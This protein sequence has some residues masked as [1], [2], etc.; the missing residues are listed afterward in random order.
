[1]IQY[2]GLHTQ[3]KPGSD[4]IHDLHLDGDGNLAICRN[5][6]AVGQHARQRVMTYEGE[7]FLDTSAGVPWLQQILG[8]K[9]D[10][11][12]TLAEAVIKTEIMETAGVI[13]IDGLTLSYDRY[14]RKLAFTGASVTTIYDEVAQV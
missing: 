2:I 7:W 6:E 14:V 3:P 9:P 13:G 4:D 12:Q 1:M 5:T 8:K 11:V 10:V